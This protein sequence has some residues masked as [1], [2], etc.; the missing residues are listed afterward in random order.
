MAFNITLFRTHD[1][2]DIVLDSCINILYKIFDNVYVEVSQNIIDIPK[3]LYD[4]RRNQ[5]L[6]E[7]IVYIIS[8][9]LRPNVYG[10]I[11]ANVDAYVYGLNF[12]FGLAIPQ[13]R[14]AAVFTYRLRMRTDYSNYI[15]RVQKEIV[16]ELG[17]LL[18]LSH[19]L[20]PYCVMKF[21]NNV[22]EVDTKGALFCRRCSEKLVKKGFKVKMSQE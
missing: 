17:H 11:I 5:Y 4:L 9:Y 12:V 14:S 6:A 8:E 22:L 18:G 2:E 3:D 7:G 19:C 16:H 13:V 10:I 21:S 15:Y 1:I 20:T